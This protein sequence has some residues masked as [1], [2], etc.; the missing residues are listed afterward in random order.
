MIVESPAKQRTISRFLKKGYVVAS[1]YGHVRDLPEKKLGVAEDKDFEPSYT[2]LPRTKKLLPELK[3][4]VKNS[5]YVYLATDHDREGE[6]IAWH[7][8]QILELDESRAKRIT[9]HEI[10]PQAIAQALK[11]PRSVDM[12]L[13]CAQQARRVIDRLVGYKISPLL[14]KKIRRGLS[15]GRVQSVAVRLLVE[16]E[17]E[18]KAFES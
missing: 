7:L 15:A 2:L 11:S 10:T 1:S 4:L 17:K 3:K 6:S 13:V 14:W 18:I 16:R 5:Q 9:F 8:M 12:N